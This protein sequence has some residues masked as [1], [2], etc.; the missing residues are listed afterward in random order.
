LRP[1]A[2]VLIHEIYE[3][4]LD[5][6][7]MA[8]LPSRLAAAVGARSST[9]QIYEGQTPVYLASSYFS[10]EMTEFYMANDVVS[11]DCWTPLVTERGL[12]NQAVDADM[13]MSRE[14]FKSTAFHNEFFRRFGD[15]TGY[16]LG[17]VLKTR[18]GIVGLG[19]HHALG[20]KS[21]G[22][23]GVETL[24]AVLPHLRRL[25]EA[26]SVLTVADHRVR[27][28]EVLLHAQAI[29]ILLVDRLGRI[30]FANAAAERILA[31]SDGLVCRNGFLRAHGLQ[32]ARLEAAISQVV[33][34]AASADAVA[35]ARPSEAKAYHVLITPHRGPGA[36]P[37]RGM[38][39]IEDPEQDDP[40]IAM[41]LRSLFD[42]SA[43]QA[44]LAARL[45]AGETLVEASENR[46]VL[47]STSRTQLNGVLAKTGMGRQ[48]ELMAMIG[49]L[50]RAR[51][52][53]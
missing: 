10:G 49:R 47:V 41:R 34:A 32:G 46:G 22:D 9:F 23:A 26:R 29:A 39:L 42:L 44:D 36:R 14:Q 13:F 12:F 33:G 17:A 5:E 7:A 4:L 45:F 38:I 31:R 1:S 52:P 25:V 48:S 24:N 51:T 15:D 18:S 3:A 16:S 2:D 30:A 53:D 8:L 40:G 27:D 20:A 37:D 50:P 19:L 28:A 6:E 11:L 35:I 43:A 21:Y